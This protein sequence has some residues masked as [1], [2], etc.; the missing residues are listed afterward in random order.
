[1]ISKVFVIATGGKL[2]Y[3]KNFVTEDFVDKEIVSGFLSA[4]KD[5]AEEITAGK[6]VNFNFRNFNFIYD[7]DN[8]LDCMFVLVVDVDD[9]EDEVREKLGLLK[10]E[11]LKRYRKELEQWTGNITIFKDFDG[12]VR[13]HIFIP[14]KILI[15]GENGVGKSSI[16]NLFPGE[17]VLNLDED[18]NEII[19]KP[20]RVSGL[21]GLK[22]FV[23]R[24]LDLEE[25]VNKAKN[26][27]SLLNSV[28]VIVIVSNSSK[29]NV[30]ITK[31]LFSQLKDLVKKADFYII[32]NFQDL[33][34]SV[35]EPKAIEKLFNEKTY[36]FSTK[37]PDA[38]ER[39]YSIIVEI[40]K[41]SILSKYIKFLTG[42][43]RPT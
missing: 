5:Y 35:L 26:Y 21:R 37:I 25:L 14:P 40:L 30:G 33:K 29:T 1:M 27:R 18:L 36:A 4:F 17:T 11:F 12:F 39:M 38:T 10:R 32:A 42:L 13:R 31:R 19:E 6:I 43:I 23:L 41:R 3:S 20:I 15:V 22:Q 9:I 2:C 8:D 24:E 7:Y 34:N 16:M 28:N